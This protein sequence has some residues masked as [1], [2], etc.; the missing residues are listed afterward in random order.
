M[1]WIF[2]SI[3]I[4]VF[5]FIAIIRNINI[6]HEQIDKGQDGECRV[7][8]VINSTHPKHVLNDYM[9]K[10]DG[11]TSQIDHIVINEF[12]IFVIETKN[13]SGKIYG[14]SKQL[15]WTQILAGGNI[16]NTFYNPVKQNANH[17]Y[18]LKKLLNTNSYMMSIVVFAGGDISN[19]DIDNV[20]TIDELTDKLRLAEKYITDEEAEEIYNKLLEVEDLETT[21]EAHIKEI[22]KEQY[23]ID[24]NICP[25][26]GGDLVIRHG[27]YGDFYGCSN[28]PNCRFKKKL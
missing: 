1:F 9:F 18:K 5:I 4:V 2:L 23:D 7:Y 10:V 3:I 26:C 27:K 6:E 17:I 28:Y 8:Q 16:K 13:Y 14:N 15:E 11:K 22:Y 20:C 25:R 19:I 24:H 12:G 21:E